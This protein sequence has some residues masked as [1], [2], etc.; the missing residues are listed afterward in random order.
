MYALHEYDCHIVSVGILKHMG[1]TGWY[2]TKTKSDPR[3][4]CSWCVVPYTSLNVQFFIQTISDGPVP[5]FN[6]KVQYSSWMQT[7]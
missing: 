7:S 5:R 3:I 2:L 1:K 4:H 6:I